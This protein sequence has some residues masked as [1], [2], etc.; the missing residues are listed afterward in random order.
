M[1]LTQGIVDRYKTEHPD[2]SIEQDIIRIRVE[3]ATSSLITGVWVLDAWSKDTTAMG[4][5]FDTQ[6]NYDDGTV[7]IVSEVEGISYVDLLKQIGESP[8]DVIQASVSYSDS[9][10]L[11]NERLKT[12]PF[13][14]EITDASGAYHGKPILHSTEGFRVDG[15]AK[16]KLYRIPANGY[17]T[18]EMER[19]KCIR[20][21]AA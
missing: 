21:V 1:E 6:G 16:I 9:P 4:L 19:V 18:I 14:F 5:L 8:F 15:T 7:R 17:A 12:Q 3:N 2:Y 13:I 11:V 20:A 10:I